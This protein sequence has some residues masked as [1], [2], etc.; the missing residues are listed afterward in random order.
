MIFTE[1]TKKLLVVAVASVGTGAAWMSWLKDSAIGS[2]LFMNY[3]IPATTVGFVMQVLAVLQVFA[4]VTLFFRKTRLYAA[5]FIGTYLAFLVYAAID[6]GGNPYSD[7]SFAAYAMRLAT[8]IVFFIVLNK[9]LQVRFPDVS[10]QVAVWIMILASCATFFM[11]GI[12]AIL[13]HPW[14]VDMT[15]T[16]VGHLA[17]WSISQS[18]AEQMLIIVGVLDIASA[19][20]LLIFRSKVAVIWM[21][22]WGF[23]TCL[24]RLVN[25]GFGAIPDA[26]IRLPHGILPLVLYFTLDRKKIKE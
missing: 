6:Q 25:Y 9:S 7:Y 16:M 17:G 21:I 12:E 15:I 3:N 10:N 5:G 20:G 24:L 2:M 4:V 14:F 23:F 1:P 13:A 18:L 8:P 19:I 26:I 22:I 11:H